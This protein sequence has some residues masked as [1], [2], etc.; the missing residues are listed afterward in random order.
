LKYICN[1]SCKRGFGLGYFKEKPIIKEASF[2]Y[3][4]LKLS[5]PRVWFSVDNKYRSIWVERYSVFHWFAAIGN[6]A[7]LC[8][9]FFGSFFGKLLTGISTPLVISSARRA[10]FFA[11]IAAFFLALY[12]LAII[13]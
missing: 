9:A 5:E 10:F 2:F 8:T 3:V 1:F 13:R 11:S 7:L 12:S 4:Y 6:I